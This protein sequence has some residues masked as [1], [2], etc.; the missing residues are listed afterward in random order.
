MIGLTLLDLYLH[1][2]NNF[3]WHEIELLIAFSPADH[4][5]FVRWI[6]LMELFPWRNTDYLRGPW[7]EGD[8]R[9]AGCSFREEV[10]CQSEA[11]GETPRFKMRRFRKRQSFGFKTIF[12]LQFRSLKTA[13]FENRFQS[14]PFWKHLSLCLGKT[15]FL[16]PDVPAQEHCSCSQYFFWACMSSS[17]CV[18]VH[19]RIVASCR[20]HGHLVTWYRNYSFQQSVGSHLKVVIPKTFPSGSLSNMKT[21]KHCCFR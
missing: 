14:A 15:S 10:L 6:W 7:Q 12:F 13:L 2:L 16:N 20:T 17:V 9:C 11:C 1:T 21:G 8:S 19:V 3:L 18:H 4:C 5:I